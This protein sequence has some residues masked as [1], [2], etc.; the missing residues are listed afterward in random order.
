MKLIRKYFMTAF[1]LACHSLVFAQFNTLTRKEIKANE[2]SE[3]QNFQKEQRDR[4]EIDKKNIINKLFNS[5]T[6]TNL[7]KEMDSLK[8]M[9]L[10]YSVSTSEGKEESYTNNDDSPVK[11]EVDKLSNQGN[12]SI[13]KS[14]KKFDL[15]NEEEP[16][17]KISMPLNRKIVVTSPF[18]W[19]VHPI[20][21]ATKLHNGADFKANYENVYAVLDGIVTA[22]GWDSGGGGNYIKVRHS[23]TFETSYLHLSEIYYRAGEAVKAGFII[24]KSGN[25]GN[26]TGAHLHFSVTENGKYINPIRFL[27][28][29]IKAN[30]LIATYYEAGSN[31]N[32]QY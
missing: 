7:K 4:K 9:V 1:V 10:R 19:R 23:G 8:T 20:F 25:T 13:V 11:M 29:L 17:S 30:N 32:I 22:A 5:P 28:Y 31:S 6:K 27:N 14:I 16:I 12:I 18:G 15:I 21:G 24:A 2:N 26:S 3:K